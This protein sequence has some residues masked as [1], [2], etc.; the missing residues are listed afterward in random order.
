MCGITSTSYG[1]DSSVRTVALTRGPSSRS[2]RGTPDAAS[3]SIA[4]SLNSSTHGRVGVPESPQRERRAPGRRPSGGRPA[5]SPGR[6]PRGARSIAPGSARR[7]RRGPPRARVRDAPRASRRAAASNAA[8][9]ASQT[10]GEARTLP[11]ATHSLPCTSAIVVVTSAPLNDAVAPDTVDDRELS[12]APEWRRLDE[13][14]N[15]LGCRMPDPKEIEPR[16]AESWVGAML[17]EHDA[18]V[19]LRERYAGADC[20][21]GGCH[22]GTEGAGTSAASCERVGQG[23]TMSRAS[24]PGTSQT[25]SGSNP[26]AVACSTSL[27][28]PDTAA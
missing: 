24:A 4:R 6:A 12:P 13:G 19:C 14:C 23:V 15:G 5:P 1:S 9:I 8:T 11:I 27:A 18:D 3:G 25:S 17:R 26:K 2:G 21:V 20:D 28:S 22:A 10:L 7:P 16:G